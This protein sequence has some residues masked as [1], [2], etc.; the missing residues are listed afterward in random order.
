MNLSSHNLQLIDYN[1]F[2]QN[3]GLTQDDF[4]NPCPS[5]ATAQKAA[6]KIHTTHG[7]LT[8]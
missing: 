4:S 3:A 8:K 1:L 7:H 5:T 6:L 2:I